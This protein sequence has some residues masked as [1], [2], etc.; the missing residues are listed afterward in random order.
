MPTST[1]YT[2]WA[3]ALGRLAE[4]LAAGW[5]PLL[6]AWEAEPVAGGRLA[7]VVARAVEAAGDHVGAGRSEL[8][9]LQE[10]CE[11]RAV[12]CADYTEALAGYHRVRGEYVE[13]RAAFDAGGGGP[14]PVA[15]VAPPRPAPWAEAGP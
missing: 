9:A 1:A 13:A 6:A 8:A 2:A 11:R 3:A 5:E 15:P 10:E 12:V 14:V 4:D 7:L